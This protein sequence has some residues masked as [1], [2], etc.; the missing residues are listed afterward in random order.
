MST[1]NVRYP[2][3]SRGDLDGFFGLMVD[4]LAQVLLIVALCGGGA[5]L[6]QSLIFGTILPGVAVSLVIG[7]LFYGI[8]AHV[9][10]RSSG[11]SQTTALPYGINTP[12]VY[13]YVLFIMG[14]VFQQNVTTMGEDAAARLAW[15]AGLLACVVS[16]LIEFFG[17][18]VAEPLRRVTPR[19]AL[20]GV[21]AVVGVTFIAGD[22]AFR[23][24][25]QPLVGLPALAVLLLAYFSRYSFPFGLPGGAAAVVVGTVAAW[26]L[27]LTGWAGW[28]G[29]SEPRSIEAVR[30]AFAQLGWV[31]PKFAGPELLAVFQHA[32]IAWTLLTV[33]VPMGLLNALG[34]LQNIES[35]EAAGDR[36]AT[37]P[38]LAVNGIG[39]LAAA[40]FGS[41]FPTT[42]YIGHPG[43]K[44]LGARA[45]YSILNGVFF[46]ACFLLGLG[47]LLTA[48]IPIEAG[49]A[50]VLYIGVIIA[51]Q[52][53]QA[54]P[55]EHAPAIALC[56][57]PALAALLVVNVTQFLMAAGAPR[58]LADLLLDPSV[59]ISVPALKGLLLLCGANSSWLILTLILAATGVA[60]I[61]RRFRA[62]AAWS[63][64]AAA[65]TFSGL[66]HAYQV[67][68][69]TIRELFI[70][71]PAPTDSAIAYSRA[72]PLT[73]AY[74]FMA[75]LFGAI[76][77]RSR[78]SV[79]AA[80][81]T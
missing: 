9:V 48:L 34:S 5:H 20:L 40:L 11:N 72:W 10:A 58:S 33:A 43:W 47:P 64:V 3:W 77:L 67:Q 70:W 54:T 15:Q 1:A 16:G 68:G 24:Y 14:P 31:S 81:E 6:P 55:R 4:N 35:A 22:F 46:T 37:M 30:Q 79:S 63:A 25:T 74:S 66:M 75:L 2:L 44:A 12:S 38:S 65:L 45:G 69:Q 7:N 21:L 27:S 17:A 19:A 50:I 52:A 51:A 49:A 62:A 80:S 23:M 56:F 73:V 29:I 36:F 57:F 42:I 26:A 41:C 71:Q 53:F 32:E 39:T 59:N 18:F 13:A 76:A 78:K 8:Q 61:D 60:L 28:G